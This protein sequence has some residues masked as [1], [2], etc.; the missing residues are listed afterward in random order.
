[1]R[2]AAPALHN[3]AQDRAQSS[4]T[5]HPTQWALKLRRQHPWAA[6]HT[7]PLTTLLVPS[8][9]AAHSRTHAHGGGAVCACTAALQYPDA[10]LRRQLSIMK[11]G[12]RLLPIT[13]ML[14]WQ[15]PLNR[16]P[17][18]ALKAPGAAGRPRNRRALPPRPSP[19]TILWAQSL[20]VLAVCCGWHTTCAAHDTDQGLLGGD[21]CQVQ[22]GKRQASLDE[23]DVRVVQ[24]LQDQV[25]HQHCLPEG[26]SAHG[27]QRR[28]GPCCSMRVLRLL[29]K[30]LVCRDEQT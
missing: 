5:R 12:L 7:S 14:S 11:P 10:T 1:M 19:G 25:P 29:G 21:G 4:L 15:E 26:V 18:G 23:V 9:C 3:P 27:E 30:I 16:E 6:V 20:H 2:L 22:V 24:P 17:T 13:M 8:P 28:H